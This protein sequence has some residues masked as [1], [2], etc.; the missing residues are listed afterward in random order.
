MKL[1]LQLYASYATL[2][3]P[4]CAKYR[5]RMKKSPVQRFPPE[6]VERG[7]GEEATETFS[8]T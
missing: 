7:A 3:K 5:Q 4:K 1:I 8:M 6:Q 2:S